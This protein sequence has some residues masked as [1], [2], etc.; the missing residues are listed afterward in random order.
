MKAFRD[1][2]MLVDL[3]LG[4]EESKQY[5]KKKKVSIFQVIK[6]KLQKKSLGRRLK[7]SESVMV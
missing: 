6:D 1:I 5:Q 4:E 7:A 2:V 3:L